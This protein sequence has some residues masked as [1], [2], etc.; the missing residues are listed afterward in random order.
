M[1]LTY[2]ELYSISKELQILTTLK[3]QHFFLS[4]SRTF[5]LDFGKYRCL[6]GLQEPFLRIHLTSKIYPFK[7]DPFAHSIEKAIKGKILRSVQLSS[8]DRRFEF[9][10]ESSKLIVNLIP[11]NPNLI[12]DHLHLNPIKE[13][14][15]KPQILNEIEI[16]SK[17]IEA[18]YEQLI[19][20][21]EEEERRKKLEILR[22]KLEADLRKALKWEDKMRYALLV[23]SSLFTYEPK[24]H[25]LI[26]VGEEKPLNL[27]RNKTPHAYLE[28][29]LKEAKRLKSEVDILQKKL[30]DLKLPDE[31]KREP[32]KPYMEYISQSGFKIWVGRSA[33]DNDKLTFTLAKGSDLWLHAH[34]EKGAHVVIRAQKGAPF[35]KETIEE[36]KLLALKHSQGKNKGK[37]EVVITHIKNVKKT[38]TKGKVFVSDAKLE[39]ATLRPLP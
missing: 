12:L 25:S 14:L 10:F 38:K 30:E 31:K 23:Q 34:H 37:A 8:A 29:L 5:I 13:S 20:E 33:M 19:R 3:I 6:I 9:T 7:P 22:K 11:R 2:S 4:S 1:S 16:S 39:W 27:P 24:S 36:A 21:K 18:R 35:D 28:A 26:L 17:E 32:R 15:P